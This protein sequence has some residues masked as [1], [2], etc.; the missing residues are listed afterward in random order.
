[1]QILLCQNRL[2]GKSQDYVD[3]VV[4][5]ELVH[6]F[7]FCRAQVQFADVR[8]HACTEVRAANLS[9]ECSWW[10]EVKRGVLQ[11]SGHQE[12]CVR[13]R[14]I[15]SVLGNPAVRDVDDA[16][17]VVASVFDRCYRDLQPHGSI[18]T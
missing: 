11:W 13:R 14:A 7:D 6:S 9:G 18:P 17:Q 16:R 4:S 5:H 8:H 1:M 12:K 3:T 2:Q 10:R 15:V